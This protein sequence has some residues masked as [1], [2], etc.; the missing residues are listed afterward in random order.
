MN[1]ILLRIA[2]LVC[3]VIFAFVSFGF[4]FEREGDYLFEDGVFEYSNN[5][6]INERLIRNIFGNAFAENLSRSNSIFEDVIS[7]YRVIKPVT[8]SENSVFQEWEYTENFAGVWYDSNGNLNVGVTNRFFERSQQGV[9]YN[10]HVFSY[11]FLNS[12]QGLV[13]YLMPRYSIISSSVLP[14]YNVVEI[15]IS[16]KAYISNITQYLSRLSGFRLS[17]INFIFSTILP[18]ASSREIHSGSRVTSG[19][20]RTGTLSAKARCLRT[21]R[22]GVITNQHVSPVGTNLRLGGPL[23]TM[24]GTTTS[25]QYGGRIDASF[26]PFNDAGAWNFTSSAAHGNTVIPRTYLA[27]QNSIVVGLPVVK[28]GQT[29]GRT[30]GSI[31]SLNYGWSY[32]N[33]V[34]FHNKIQHTAYTRSGDSGSPLFTVLAD[35][36]HLQLGIVSH[37]RFGQG[38]LTAYASNIWNV[39]ADLDVMLY[40]EFDGIFDANCIWYQPRFTTNTNNHGTITA[41]GHSGDR[42]PFGAFDGWQGFV[43]EGN[44]QG[45]SAAQWTKR[46]RTG[47]IQ[48]TLNYDII[49]HR[50]DFYNRSAASGTTDWTEYAR[51]SG[52]NGVAL[53]VGFSGARANMGRNRIHVGGV[54]TNIIRLDIF[55][56]WGNYIGANEIVI[57]AHLA[58]RWQ[59]PTWTSNTNEHGTITASHANSAGRHP[60]GAFDGWV[61]TVAAGNAA[62]FPAAQWTINRTNGWLQLT[63]NYYIYVHKIEFFNRSSTARNVTRNANFTGSNGVALGAPFVGQQSSIGR[64]VISVDN[65]R[66]RVIRLNI[67]SSWGDYVGANAIVIHGIKV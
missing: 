27:Q 12:V 45:F 56:S 46:G 8:M 16:D 5:V 40:N 38:G 17:A 3:L 26:T 18:E 33:G 42:A 4:S 39:M 34:R 28:F 41:S 58:D 43:A 48:L 29:T 25:G 7:R 51:F 55:N 63:L 20:L 61:G 47:W 50:I 60:F 54:R 14:Q 59:Q 49:V 6:E 1:K 23:G 37:S 13:S 52:T 32:A 9:I 11:N 65:V 31:R 19:G 67:T 62:G 15:T 64:S 10:T 24:I 2:T 22:M 44:R 57:Y 35:G 53:G 30:I 36:R 21:R 66:T